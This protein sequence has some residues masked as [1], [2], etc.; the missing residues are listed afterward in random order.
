MPSNR[1]H[2]GLSALR[3][4]ECRMR[5]PQP[6]ADTQHWLRK[7]CHRTFHNTADTIVTRSKLEP[8]VWMRYLRCFV[9]R[10]PYSMRQ[11][12]ADW[13]YVIPPYMDYWGNH[14]IDCMYTVSDMIVKE[15]RMANTPTTTMRLDPEIKDA[16]LQ[17]LEP[18]GLNLTSAVNIFLKAVISEKRLPFEVTEK[19][20]QPQVER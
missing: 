10:L 8:A 16:A 19:T 11:H 13:A 6:Y 12:C 9:D 17:I 1:R 7:D 4:V 18:L 5:R 20:Q 2:R 3:L 14:S 15:L